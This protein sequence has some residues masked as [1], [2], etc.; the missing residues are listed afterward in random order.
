[1]NVKSWYIMIGWYTEV[2]GGIAWVWI[3]A[4]RIGIINSRL[5]GCAAGLALHL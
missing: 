1:M 2:M 3:P 5:S 4:V